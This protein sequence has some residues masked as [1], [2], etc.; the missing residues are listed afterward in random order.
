M[1]FRDLDISDCCCWY[2]LPS[3]NEDRRSCWSKPSLPPGT[4]YRDDA[5]DGIIVPLLL[6]CCVG[7]LKFPP[8]PPRPPPD[9]DGALESFV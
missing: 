9:D 7:V 5:D 1:P 6:E 8:R 4:L 2:D 3:C